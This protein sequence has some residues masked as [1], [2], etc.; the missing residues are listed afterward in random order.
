MRQDVDAIKSSL[1]ELMLTIGTLSTLLEKVDSDNVSKSDSDVIKD[2]LSKAQLLINE[3]FPRLKLIRK[4]LYSLKPG[5]S[6]ESAKVDSIM[7]SV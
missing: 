4:E 6:P 1:H 3:S 5:E 2:G 7:R